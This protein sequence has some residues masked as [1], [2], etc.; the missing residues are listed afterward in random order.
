MGSS[1]PLPAGFEIWFGSPNFQATGNGYLMRIINRDELHSR[2]S[3]GPGPV[4]VA[5]AA[6]APAPAQADAAGP[7]ALQ[8]RRRS[9]Q[10]SRQARTERRRAAHVASQRDGIAD[11]TAT[12]PTGGGGVRFP[13]RSSPSACAAP[14]WRTPRP[15]APMWQRARAVPAATSQRLGTSPPPP[16][17]SRTTAPP[18][19]CRP[20]LRTGTRSGTSPACRTQ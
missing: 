4:P 19:S 6:D 12:A 8:R 9:G 11:E 5:P 20:P 7:S 1:N 15:P 14:Q 2:R 13:G 16:T 3:N 10:R 18:A 17:T